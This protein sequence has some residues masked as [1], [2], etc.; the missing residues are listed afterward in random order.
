[1]KCI[2][3]KAKKKKT[4]SATYILDWL[5]YKEEASWFYDTSNHVGTN[6]YQVTHYRANRCV[7]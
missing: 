1:M 7:H 6:G 5:Y 2:C 3:K 4:P